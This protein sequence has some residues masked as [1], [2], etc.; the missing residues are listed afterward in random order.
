MV[1]AIELRRSGEG[2]GNSMA[3]QGPH[4]DIFKVGSSIKCW[5]LIKCSVEAAVWLIN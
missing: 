4:R 5:K 2:G 3:M 1:V